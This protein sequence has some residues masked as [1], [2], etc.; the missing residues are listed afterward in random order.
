MCSRCALT[1]FTWTPRTA[2]ICLLSRPRTM[3]AIT[4][5]MRGVSRANRRWIKRRSVEMS[6]VRL[7]LSSSSNVRGTVPASIGSSSKSPSSGRFGSESMESQELCGGGSVLDAVALRLTARGANWLSQ[8]CAPE[9]CPKVRILQAL[10]TSYFLLLVSMSFKAVSDRIK[11][12]DW[13][14][15][16]V[17]H[18]S[19]IMRPT[20]AQ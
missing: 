1:V 18:T 10:H 14:T 8:L 5:R 2:A 3:C 9:R 4:C 16:R 11:G 7:A 12:S 13:T 19:R 17:I 6:A 15:L 20:T